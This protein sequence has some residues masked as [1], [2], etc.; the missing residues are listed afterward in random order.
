MPPEVKHVL[1]IDDDE[2][3]RRRVAGLLSE[4]G[5]DVTAVGEGFSAVRLAAGRHFA[6]ALVAMALP[7]ALDG[8]RTV[9]Q[10]RALQPQLKAL[11]LGEAAQWLGCPV[12]ERD[13]FIAAPFR[14]RDLLG[15]V[16]ELLQREPGYLDRYRCSRAG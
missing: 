3:R 11:L 6:L 12:G 16:F 4:E 14:R 2:E 1:V 13:D 5:F 10:L 15:C 7:G 8:V 9:R